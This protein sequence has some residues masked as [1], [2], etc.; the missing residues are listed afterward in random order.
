MFAGIT[1]MSRIAV[2]LLAS[3]LAATPTLAQESAVKSAADAFGERVGTEQSGLYNESE[4][5]G[6]D[7]NDSGA[8]RIEDAYFSR[9]SQLNDPVLAGVGVRVGVNAARLPYPSPSGVV[10][11]RLRS[12]G[13][14][15][16]VRLAAGFR[17]YGTRVVQGD[18]SWKSEDQR[19]GLAGGFVGRPHVQWAPGSEG[20]AIDVGGVGVWNVAPNQR[21]RVFGSFYKR[22]YD[23]DYAFLPTEAALPPD[24]RRSHQYSPDWARV[25]ATNANGG[26]LYDGRFGDWT[27]DASAFR[28]IFD[29]DGGDFTLISVDGD[30][31]ATA[32]TYRNPGRTNTSDSG[33]VRLGRRFDAGGLSHLVT[34]SVRGR[35]STVELTSS[36]AIPLGS[37][38]IRGNEPDGIEQAW[39]GTRGKDEVEQVTGSLGYGLAWGD[40]LQAR[41]AVHRTRYDKEVL[42]KTGARTEGVSEKTLYNASAIL[43][44]TPRTALFGSWVTGLEESGVAPTSAT[45]RDEVLPPVESE[46][47]ELGVRHNVTPGLVF[48]GALFDVSKPRPGFRADGSYGLVGQVRHRGV[49]GSLAGQV[50]AKTTAVLGAVAFTPKVSGPLVDAGV[51]GARAAGVSSLVVN[52][53]VERQIAQG[54]SMDAQLT[55]S[56]ERWVDTANTFKAP[57]MTLLSLG[58]R[59]R[60]EL[61]GRP[62]QFRILASN[63]TGEKGYSASASGLLWPI[64]P[65][66]VR[67]LLTVTFGPGT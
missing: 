9:A 55:Y 43:S 57:A 25:Q 36:V 46:Q 39:S 49:E 59:R 15:N 33:E 24:P 10:N 51:V 12:P 63:V 67:A 62:A 30:G 18:V 11:Y 28:S 27:V 23:G 31:D 53:S 21:L 29:S 40:R 50:D 64:N 13:P 45:N 38:N 42:T 54:W 1:T 66:T 47:F 41:A 37:F 32:T 48:I 20:K 7:I 65:R 4:V 52:A 6:F 3:L 58:A 17:D 35:R 14:V 26:V 16:E 61:A 2:P 60:F 19:F 8:Y 22:R 5:R 34:A 44:V 56:G